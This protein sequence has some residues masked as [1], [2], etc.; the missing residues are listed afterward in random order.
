[1]SAGFFGISP[2][3]T[4]PWIGPMKYLA[5][6]LGDRYNWAPFQIEPPAAIADAWN[7]IQTLINS[8]VLTTCPANEIPPD[9]QFC[10]ATDSGG[11]IGIGD[12]CIDLWAP[13]CGADR[14]TYSN[15]CY[16]CSAGVEWYV[17]G[18]CPEM[19]VAGARA[20]K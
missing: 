18:P 19:P 11:S 7:Q 14:Y 3:T 20:L 16:A 9:A 1:M 8:D 4:E 6:Q 12:A 15:N 2:D 17:N 5:M 10:A 13:V